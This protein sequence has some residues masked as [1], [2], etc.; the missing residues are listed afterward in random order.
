[1]KDGISPLILTLFYNFRISIL[2][3]LG[4][5]VYAFIITECTR[6]YL[7]LKHIIKVIIY[8]H[9]EPFHECFLRE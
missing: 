2:M 5:D 9:L 1:M 3:I 8:A 6:L 4:V 7:I